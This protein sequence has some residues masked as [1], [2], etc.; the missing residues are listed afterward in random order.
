MATNRNAAWAAGCW[1][2]ASAVLI[3]FGTDYVRC[4]ACETL[5]FAGAPD[6]NAWDVAADESGFYGLHFHTDDQ[7]AAGLPGIEE[8]ARADLPERCM[9]W[10][11]TL[12]RYHRPSARLLEIGAS[13]GGFLRLAGLAGFHATGIDLSPAIVDLARAWFDVDMRLGPLESAGFA[14]EA[15]DVV[16]AFDVLEH[17]ARPEDTLREIRRVLRPDGVLLMQ[18]PNF[19]AVDR[20][21]LEAA[22]DPF[23]KLLGGPAHLTLFSERSARAILE[24]AGFPDVTFEPPIFPADMFFVAGRALPPPQDKNEVARSLLAT[25]DGRVALALLDVLENCAEMRRVAAER[26]A[27]IEGLSAACDERLALI[28][29]L[30]R[31]LRERV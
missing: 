21:E 30:D 10:L 19:P 22:N 13:H 24:R 4:T 29:R 15:F 23:L 20:G 16:V 26:L 6:P 1:C 11:R 27:V 2:D 25:P 3:P 5:V 7:V 12:L 14:D 17:L 9:H 31:Q 28:E 8:R 18:T